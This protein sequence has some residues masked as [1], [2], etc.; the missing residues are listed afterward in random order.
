MSRWRWIFVAMIVVALFLL[1]RGNPEPA[2]EPGSTLVVELNGAYVDGTVS[3]LLGLVSGP[4]QSLLGAISRLRK[5]ERD[6]RIERVVFR[7]RGVQMGWGQAED[8]RSAI[9]RLAESGKE[10]VALL[11]FEGYGNAPYY[12]ASAAD[13]VVMTPGAHSPFVG[14]AI[15]SLFFAG[16]LEKAGVE[17]EYERI[18]KYKSAVESYGEAKASDANR[19]MLSAMLDSV[20][21]SFVSRVAEA[22]EMEADAVRAVIDAAPSSATDMVAQGL[23]DEVAHYDELLESLGDPPVVTAGTYDRVSA[24]KVGFEAQD[25]FAIVYGAGP[26]VTGKADRSPTGARAMASEVI[27]DSLRT[28]TEDESI[29]AIIFRVNS[30]GGSPLASDLIL[31]EVVRAQEAGKPVIVSMSDYAASGGYFVAS[32]ADRIVSQPATLTG[33]IGVY[34]LRPNLRGLYEKLGVGVESMT[35]GAR[36]EFLLDDRSLTPETRALL[37]RQVESIY[38]LFLDRVVEGREMERDAVHAVAQGRV[39]TGE[40]ALEVG[41][42][43]RLGGYFEAVAEARELVGLEPGTDVALVEFPRPKPLAQQVAEMLGGARVRAQLA[44][45]PVPDRLRGLLETFAGLP[46]GE[47]LL[48]APAWIEIR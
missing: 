29:S 37:E 23:A 46:Q 33:S 32:S 30:P 5:A 39:W 42:V 12:L 15:Q 38:S 16:A 44:A 20:E 24:Q 41:L 4:E 25:T 45:L 18:G 3:P 47:P 2:I 27:V 31:R 28:A 9:R 8:L 21:H 10:T 36:A 14:L 11:E 7:I 1:F 19:E 48:L 26:V 35:R 13:R 17:F 34:T 40:Q 6:D 22:R 43:D